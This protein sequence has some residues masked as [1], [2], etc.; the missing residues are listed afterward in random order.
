MLCLFFS[1]STNAQTRITGKVTGTDNIPLAGVTVAVKDSKVRVTTSEAGIFTLT[2]QDNSKPV[3]FFS[4][5]GYES[6]EYRVENPASVNVSMKETRSS[7]NE[8]VVIGYGTQRR[9]DL[10]GSVGSV[11]ISDLN[12][13]PV[14]SFDDALAGRISGVSV[15]SPD[16]QPGAASDIVIRGGNSVTQ[17]NSPL[18]VVDGFPIE[19]Y[20]NNAINPRDIESIEVLK[21]AS[22]T[23]IYGARGANGVI[24]ITTKK[25][26]AGP[27]VVEYN[28]YYG[29]QTNTNN[30]ALM[31]P[32]EFVRLQYEVDSARTILEYLG[33]GKSLESYRGVPSL[34][35]QQQV[36]RTAAMQNHNVSVRG[37]NKDTKYSMAGSMFQQ[38]G[39]LIGSSFKRYQGRVTLDQNLNTK[40]KVGINVN[41]ATIATKGLQ[42][43]GGSQTA[44]NILINVWQ[45][46]PIN[47]TGNTDSLLNSAQDADVITSTNYQWNPV[48]TAYN[49]IRNR[50]TKLLTV[51]SYLDYNL[52]PSLRLRISG[53]VNTSNLRYDVFNTSQSRLGSPVSS[54]GQ[55][56]PNGSST[57][58][59]LNNFVN[60][61]TLTFDKVINKRH[62]LNVVAGF[63]TQTNTAATS[64]AGAILVPNESLGVAGLSQGT[65][66]KITSTK[67]KNTLASFLARANYSFESRYL[68]TVSFRTDGSSK[69]VG[70]NKWGYFPSGALAWHL[71]EENFMKHIGIISDAKLRGSYGITGNNRVSDFA[72]FGLIAQGGGDSYAPGGTFISGAYASSLSNPNL[73]WETT[74]ETDLGFDLGFLNQRFTLTAD[75]YNKKTTNLLLN[76]QLPTSTGYTTAF[77]NIGV[78]QNRGI[79]FSLTSVNIN[80]SKVN[81]S[82]SFNIAFNKTKVLSLAQNQQFMLS[83]AK[84][85]N[86]GVALNP[87]FI[88][89]VGNPVA[90]YFGFTWIGNYQFEDFDQP[91][92]GVYVLKSTVP[93]NG[94]PRSG[95]RPGD[96]KYKD[97]NGDGVVDDKDRGIIGNP[98]PKFIGGLANNFTYGHFDLNIFFQFVYGNDLLNINRLF[99]EGNVANLWGSNQFASYS[100]RWSPT[101]P[102]NENYRALGQGPAVYSSRVIEDGSF[103]R[104]K[105]LNIG[106]TVNSKLFQRVKISS[107][108]FYVS[109]QNLVTWTKYS[110]LDPEVNNYNSALT[111]GVDYSAYP[112]ARVMTVG[113]D[114]T[115]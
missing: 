92:P 59:E 16:G 12:K 48:L 11:K 81:W 69:F 110:G 55:G 24:I 63:T 66:F 5:V 84:F 70:K 9:R 18:Y 97:I 96:I 82:T 31:D 108:R 19:N 101:N 73:K 107:L 35:W 52:L 21:D 89:Q 51:N 94:N 90:M 36:F 39:T 102:T 17:D 87:N 103:I 83:N 47:G 44:N 6:R 88:A 29:L 80:H 26:K 113:I 74:A 115:F 99:M 67:S 46:R 78:V 3:L 65:P 93:N 54:L 10:T 45:Y 79:E 100:N 71:S 114:L 77:E 57:F 33:N 13:A 7:L 61:N 40:I 109:G 104:L 50:T 58:T 2:L 49:E 56:G 68:L 62:G 27:P 41:Y 64:G 43:G 1:L 14:K 4:Y 22:S 111:P 34:D 98:N 42:S 85:A 86:T 15:T 32:Y 53:G 60:E 23:A 20:N 91:S 30:M 72:S 8:V 105:T 106:Y 28:A 75:A 37:G 38:D 95:I 112:R 76:A 25:G